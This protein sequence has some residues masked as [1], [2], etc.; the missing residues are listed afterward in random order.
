MSD[1]ASPTS[2]PAIEAILRS[3]PIAGEGVN[4][5]LFPAARKLHLLKIEPEEIE[6]LL[7]EA[8]ADCGRAMKP[9][10]ISR[11]VRNSAPGFLKQRPWRRSWPQRNYEQIEAIGAHG[12]RLSELERRSPNQLV[13]SQANSETIIDA[14]FPGD[15]LLC[16]GPSLNL[17]LTRS[18]EAWRG[19]LERQQF[20]VP[21]SMSK[22]KGL[23]Q[24]GKLSSRSQ[25]NVGPR[26]FLVIEFDFAETDKNGCDTAAAPMLRRLAASGV[27]IAD[28]CAALHAELAKIRPI[29]LVVHSGGKSLHG[30]YPCSGV[31]ENVMHRFMRFAVRLGADPATWTRIQL[32]RMPSGIR[33]N[34]KGQR[35]LYFNPAV[36]NGGAK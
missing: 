27:T 28:L 16:A 18:R 10:E 33:D 12:M 4:L 22:T 26:Q 32:V 14:L 7:E 31:D 34:G 29:T 36:L 2:N 5:W 1:F 6:E 20:I 25:D 9:H 35:V 21:S 17:S 8:T 23:T 19:F 15:P 3:C 24:E 11:A 30:W 13:P